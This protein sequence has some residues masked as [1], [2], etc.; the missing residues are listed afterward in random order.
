M[1]YAIASLVLTIVAIGYAWRFGARAE[2]TGAAIFAVMLGVDILGHVFVPLIFK[3]VDP[4]GVAVD[5]IGLIG[6]SWLG[7]GSR[8]LWP[9]W[10]ASLQLLSTGAHLVRALSIPLRPPV[11][12]WMKT[13]PT[14]T[15]ALLLIGGTLAYQRRESWRKRNSSQN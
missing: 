1:V 12:Y 5:L 13:V 14:V 15:I 3:T 7:I 2:R 10:A 9:L 8:R 11:Y 6:F 4:I